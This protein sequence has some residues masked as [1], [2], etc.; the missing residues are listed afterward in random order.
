LPNAGPLGPLAQAI[1]PDVAVVTSIGTEHMTSTGSLEGTRAQKLELVKA[2]RPGGLAL[3]NGDDPHVRWMGEQTDAR[4]L[5][6]GFEPSND[7]W[8]S[9]YAQDW[10]RGS[11]FTL[12]L[13]GQQHEVRS[14]LLGRHFVYPILAALAAVWLEGLPL[15]PA[16]AALEQL[17]PTSGRLEPVQLPNGA[18]LLRDDFKGSLET[19]QTAL[20]VLAEVPA[21]RRWLL[22]GD[23]AEPPGSV[24][25]IYRQLGEQAAGAATDVLLVGKQVQRYR[26]GLTRGG[27]A[28]ERV[29]LIP[30]GDVLAA[31]RELQRVLEPGDVVLLKGRGPQMFE[32]IALGLLGRQVGCALRECSVLGLRCVRCDKLE[33]GWSGP[34][35]THAQ[36]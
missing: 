25:A 34:A 18:Y 7:V 35:P 8:A 11:R 24:G 1:Q 27:L 32:R 15:A 10:P 20:E 16:R 30:G 36:S 22:L 29:K 2:L 23:V 9:D 19:F 13:N 21:G 33:S 3:L 4:V 31:L 6:F 17:A 28:P 12:H 26:T 14:R 5:T